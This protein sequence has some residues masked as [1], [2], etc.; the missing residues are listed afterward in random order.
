MASP[1]TLLLPVIPGTNPQTLGATLQQVQPQLDAA[2]TS[3]GT[4]HY[5]RIM[6]LDRATPNLQPGGNPGDSYVIAVITEYDGSFDAYIGDFVAQVGTIFDALLQ[7][8]V[9]GAAVIPVA[10]NVAAFG[11]FIALNDASQHAPNNNPFYQAYPTTTVQ[12][13]LAC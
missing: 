7:F 4:V 2:L 12:Q 13:I 6:F 1:L 11:A 3:I 10:N 8:V 5:A 9:G